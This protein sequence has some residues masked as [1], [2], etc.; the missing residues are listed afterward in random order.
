[1]RVSARNFRGIIVYRYAG[2][3]S[4][5]VPADFAEIC[6]KQKSYPLNGL[7]SNNLPATSGLLALLIW[8]L[9]TVDKDFGNQAFN[10]IDTPFDYL[11]SVCFPIGSEPT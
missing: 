3:W 5:L 4:S 2:A 1:M 10:A 9:T 11:D 8:G 7:E 6:Q